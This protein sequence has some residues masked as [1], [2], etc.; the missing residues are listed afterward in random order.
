MGNVP[1][2]FRLVLTK[3]NTHT[4][5]RPDGAYVYDENGKLIG[6]YPEMGNPVYYKHA[7][8]IKAVNDVMN[9][10]EGVKGLEVLRANAL[11]ALESSVD[12]LMESTENLIKSEAGKQYKE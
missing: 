2:D 1:P 9:A 12:V 11:K 10:I 4:V 5:L 6:Y 3:T 8:I 7:E